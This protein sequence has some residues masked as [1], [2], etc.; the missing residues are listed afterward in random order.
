MDKYHVYRFLSDLGEVVYVGKTKQSLEKRMLAHFSNSGHLRRDQLDKVAKIEFLEFDSRAEMDIVELYYINKWKPIFNTQAKYDE[1]FL[2][3][4]RHE[5]CWEN[6]DFKIEEDTEKELPS[7]MRVEVVLTEVDA[8]IIEYIELNNKPKSAQFKMAMR[9]QIQRKHD[10]QL[11]ERIKRLLYDTMTS[12]SAGTPGDYKQ[13][14]LQE[15]AEKERLAEEL[16]ALRESLRLLV[17]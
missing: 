14:W 8:D 7:R 10:E 13:A 16:D 3:V 4:E 1:D 11:D 2:M 6:F 17:P 12:I 5:D 15:K 9:T